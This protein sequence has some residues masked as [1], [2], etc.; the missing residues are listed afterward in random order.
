MDANKLYYSS[1]KK[2]KNIFKSCLFYNKLLL[3]EVKNLL[4]N[5]AKNKFYNF[6]V[7]L[8]L[9]IFLL[10]FFFLSK[11]FFVKVVIGNFLYL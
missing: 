9:K 10:R 3:S 6:T 11:F 7:C 5:K 1:K 2:N 4:I 8:L